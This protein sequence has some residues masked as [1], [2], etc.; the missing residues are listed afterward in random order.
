MKSF[1]ISAFFVMRHLIAYKP[2]WITFSLIIA[3][4]FEFLYSQRPAI[5]PAEISFNYDANGSTNDA[6][7]IKNYNSDIMIAPEYKVNQCNDSIAYEI[8]QTTHRVKVKFASNV[9][10]MNFIVKATVTSGVGIG[11]ICEIFVTPVDLNSTVFTVDLIGTLPGTIGKRKFTWTWS[12]FALPINSPYCTIQCFNY[13]TTHTYYMVLSSPIEPMEIPWIRVLDYACVWASGHGTEN[14][15][16][17]ALMTNLYSNS[18]LKYNPGQS[19]Y[20]FVTYPYARHE[21]YLTDLLDEMEDVDCQDISMFFSILS[22]SL[23]T[24][25]NQTR[26]IDGKFTTELVDPIG[27]TITWGSQEWF[28]HQVAWMNNVYDPC[29]Q[30]HYGSAYSPFNANIDNPYKTDLVDDMVYPHDWDPAEPFVL[31]QIDPYWGYPSVIL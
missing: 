10:N 15:A 29:V 22:S 18:G 8:S 24:S 31:G 14:G 7:T 23:G 27:A 13:P 1:S 20:K 4:G 11:N 26:R 30:L 16:L 9:S 25:L 17:N 6:I 21:F 19:H 3:T 2:Y 5:W 12:A 28:F